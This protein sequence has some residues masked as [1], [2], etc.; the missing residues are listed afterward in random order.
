MACQVKQYEIFERMV[1]AMDKGNIS[2]LRK[3]DRL[4][5]KTLLANQNKQDVSNGVFTLTEEEISVF[6]ALQKYRG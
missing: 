3:A 2:Q 4:I 6:D 5:R 1:K